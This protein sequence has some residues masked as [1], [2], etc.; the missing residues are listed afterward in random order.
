MAEI[1][2][3]AELKPFVSRLAEQ[4]RKIPPPPGPDDTWGEK[5]NAL[6]RT[7]HTMQ[8]HV[9]SRIEAEDL[10]DEGGDEDE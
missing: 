9:D 3:W 2:S 5:V 7:V 10:A 6:N 4:V 1:Q 8:E